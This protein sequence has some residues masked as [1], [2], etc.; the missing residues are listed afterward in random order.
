MT[1]TVPSNLVTISTLVSVRVFNA[2][3]GGG[4]TGAQTFTVGTAATNDN[5]INAI[6]ITSVPFTNSQITTS[7]T[8]EAGEPIPSAACTTGG[9]ASTHSIWYKYTPSVS[10]NANFTTV[11]ES[12][13][14]VLQVVTGTL[15][16][17]APVLN[18]CNDANVGA[19]ENVTVAVTGGTTY[20]I[21][22]SDWAGIGGTSVL[23][24]VS[25]PAPASAGT[26]DMT[27]VGSHAGSFTEGQTGAFYT[28]SVTNSGTGPTTGTVTVVD[29]LPSQFQATTTAMTGT[30]WTC[31]LGTRSC[32][33]SDALAGG[34]SY[35]VVT[36]TF[37]VP[38]NTPAS[39]SNTVTV[40]GGGETNTA[41]DTSTDPT[42]VVLVPDMTVA[43]TNA[44]PIR[45]GDP[46]ATYTITVT[47]SGGTATTA[48]VS[49]V[50]S[51]SVGQTF[52]SLTGTG[53]TCTNATQTCT[54]SDVL[55]A[56]ASYPVVTMTVSVSNTASGS[57]AGLA[58]V[59]G[60]GETNTSNDTGGDFLTVTTSP[61]LVATSSHTGTFA[62]GQTGATYS[63]SVQ[64]GGLASTSGTVTVVDTLPASLTATAMTGTGW[65]C[66][67]ATL[68]C[69]RSDVLL[70]S[71]LYPT[72]T[73]TVN[74]SASAPASV[75]NTVTVSGGGEFNTANDTGIDPTTI[76]VS[77]LAD[78][79]IAK[80]H[81]GNFTQNQPGTYT[82]TA[83]N[84]GTGPTSGLVTVVDALPT[85]MTASTI[86]GAGW[87][88]VLATLTC[89][90]SDA[91]TNGSSYPAITLT[92]LVAGNAAA[93]LTN[94][95]TVS[96]G[97]EINSTNDSASDVTTILAASDTR[98]PRLTSE[99]SLRARWAQSTRLPSP[100]VVPAAQ[101][102]ARYPQLTPHRLDSPLPQSLERAGLVL[103]ALRRAHEPTR[104]LQAVAI[105]RSP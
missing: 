84:S 100:I 1:V 57:V 31:V 54:R 66:V 24:L 20:F 74:V 93:S 6:N 41:N 39:V 51:A 85:G 55:G 32:T 29:T 40:S 69:T 52:V 58:T 42:T 64:D 36:L 48:A 12:F 43:V 80:T 11:G 82:I 83:S 88:C 18:G 104:L 9:S 65:S 30:G 38:N 89:T 44:N 90:R 61:D 86:A 68:T 2:G 101:R 72:I 8:T 63:L 13:D 79:T 14:G 60:G 99:A 15:G 47:N 96:G 17:F 7:A 16:A 19:P 35:P 33:R 81:V 91:L 5:F 27:V 71:L 46:A 73:L 97:G 34:N 105:H 59:S 67:L 22:V 23:N 75:T 87:S 78:M 45:Q 103:S 49:V 95:V 102:S 94:T 70:S 62:Q 4:V 10:G 98:S 26:P 21:M 92:V 77:S 50:G 56:A 37:N 3:P 76:T 28:I 53:W 25:G